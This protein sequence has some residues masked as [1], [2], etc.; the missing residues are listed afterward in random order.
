M[1]VD[2]RVV[3]L[4]WELANAQCD[5]AMLVAEWDTQQEQWV[6]AGQRWEQVRDVVLQQT[7]LITDLQNFMFL[8]NKRFLVAQHGPGN[9]IM[10]ED[11]E[12]EDRDEYFPPLGIPVVI[13]DYSVLREIEDRLPGYD[14]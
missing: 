3:R 7:D 14:E 6:R 11:D 10:V 1:E 13:E 9:P 5:V 4:E 2:Q 8:V 12:E